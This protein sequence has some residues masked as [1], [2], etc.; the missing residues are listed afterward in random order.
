MHLSPFTKKKKKRD[1]S[2]GPDAVWIC[3]QKSYRVYLQPQTKH[4]VG[5]FQTNDFEND[6]TVW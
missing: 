6:K 1:Y 3:V 2:I 5:D 4:P